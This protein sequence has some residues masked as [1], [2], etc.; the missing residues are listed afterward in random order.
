MPL[1]DLDAQYPA[2]S[3]IVCEVNGLTL[4]ALAD[5]APAHNYEFYDLE[6]LCA[7]IRTRQI[8]IDNPFLQAL[9]EA[10]QIQGYLAVLNE[11]VARG[12]VRKR[13]SFVHDKLLAP[14]KPNPSAPSPTG[15]NCLDTIMECSWGLYFED[16]FDK[17]EE[18]RSIPGDEK[19]NADFRVEKDARALWI[20]CYSPYPSAEET[21]GTLEEWI[22]L[23]AR[24]K[25]QSK[26]RAARERNSELATGLAITMIKTPDLNTGKYGMLDALLKLYFKRDFGK[27]IG[28]P[29]DQ[30]WRECPGLDVVWVGEPQYCSSA[31]RPILACTWQRPLL[32]KDPTDPVRK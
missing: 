24:N 1:L 7:D 19:K 32:L 21:R 27:P 3:A 14:K 9:G 13:P 22:E 30:F 11:Y 18:E 28:E 8:P 20:D 29:P 10:T 4:E 6:R 12:F 16:I 5:R 25:W 2:L 31:F 15:F 23:W 26:F 17:V